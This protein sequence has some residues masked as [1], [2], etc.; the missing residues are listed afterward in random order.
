MTRIQSML[1]WVLSRKL[2]AMVA[3]CVALEAENQHLIDTLTEAS[4][5]VI[6]PDDSSNIVGMLV[7]ASNR[8]L[9]L[10]TRNSELM[11][12]NH[13]MRSEIGALT[14]LVRSLEW[15]IVRFERAAVQQKED[16]SRTEKARDDISQRLAL[17]EHLN[18]MLGKDLDMVEQR[19]AALA[20]Y[21]TRLGTETHDL[22]GVRSEA[23]Q[24][25]SG[26]G[27]EAEDLSCDPSASSQST[28]VRPG[29]ELSTTS[30]PL[31]NSVA[32]RPSLP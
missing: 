15:R 17:A 24:R 22:D 3:R 30:R 5:R 18:V 29:V 4:N 11:Q 26:L 21:I 27:T 20:D 8:G 9:A 6:M 16:A 7:E 12:E 28:I 25:V 10:V 23:Q 32:L 31:K 2:R 14:A 19:A 1:P 13:H